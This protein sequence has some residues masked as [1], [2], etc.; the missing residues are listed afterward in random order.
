MDCGKF[1][2]LNE[3]ISFLFVQLGC[4]STTGFE[5]TAPKQALSGVF[6]WP[7]NAR[8]DFAIFFDF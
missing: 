5:L 6:F 4:P 3:T 1:W 2:N 8:D 7:T